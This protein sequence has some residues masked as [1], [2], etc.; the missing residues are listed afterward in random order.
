MF[1]GLMSFQMFSGMSLM[2]WNLLEYTN[3]K[4]IDTPTNKVVVVDKPILIVFKRYYKSPFR[5][6]FHF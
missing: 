2:G 3:K 4:T 5:G 1:S 6:L